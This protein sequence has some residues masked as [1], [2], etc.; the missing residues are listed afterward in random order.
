MREMRSKQRVSATLVTFVVD[1][2]DDSFDTHVESTDTFSGYR[3]Q[4][5]LA[6]ALFLLVYSS[7]VS[8]LQ[9]LAILQRCLDDSQNL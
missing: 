7:R 3:A 2:R 8:E 5:V 9:S 6:P 1:E 4:P